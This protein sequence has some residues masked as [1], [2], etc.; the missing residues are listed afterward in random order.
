[1]ASAFSRGWINWPRV[2]QHRV[3]AVRQVVAAPR[4]S[5]KRCCLQQWRWQPSTLHIRRLR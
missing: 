5:M 1:M 2:A 4:H 3:V